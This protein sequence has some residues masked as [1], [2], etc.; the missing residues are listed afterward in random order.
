[1]DDY[2]PAGPEALKAVSQVVC[3]DGDLTAIED[4]F[5]LLAAAAGSN[6]ELS[7][8]QEDEMNTFPSEDNSKQKH[9]SI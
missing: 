7:P 4:Q 5:S 2:N 8:E 9:K 1:M 3:Q 6:D